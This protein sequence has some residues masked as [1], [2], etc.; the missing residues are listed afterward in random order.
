[1]RR[2]DRGVRKCGRKMRDLNSILGGYRRRGRTV[3]CVTADNV[4]VKV[5]S[6]GGKFK[7]NGCM[8]SPR[9][10]NSKII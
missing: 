6:E 3:E 10:E 7:H 1:M 4:F 8:F 2:E 9:I 5:R